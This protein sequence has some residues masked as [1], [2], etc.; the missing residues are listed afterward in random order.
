MIPNEKIVARLKKEYPAGTRIR[1]LHMDD[2]YAVPQG[3]LG[4]VYDVDDTGSLMVHWD[5]G[6]G[7]NVIYGEDRVERI[8]VHGD[9][10]EWRHEL[11][12][13]VG[14]RVRNDGVALGRLLFEIAGITEWHHEGKFV[15]EGQVSKRQKV[16]IETDP[17]D[18]EGQRIKIIRIKFYR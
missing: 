15:F 17:L 13:L 4:T 7:L 14:L 8:K 10:E 16:W 3:T 2:P 9:P 1:L 5:N 18:E 11:E 6:Q 12:D